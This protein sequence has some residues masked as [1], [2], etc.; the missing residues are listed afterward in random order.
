VPVYRIEDGFI[1][2]AGLGAKLVPP[3]SI[4]V[5]CRGA[6]F[7]PSTPSDLEVLLEAGGFDAALLAR[8]ERLAAAI[9]AR[10][11]T[12]YNLAGRPP[13][14]PAGRRLVLV[15]GQVTDDRSVTHGGAGIV[16]MAQL[17][18]RVRAAEPDAFI[19]FKPHPD[20]DARLRRGAL[21]DSEALRHVDRVIRGAALAPLLA[22]VDAVHVLSSQTGFEAL[23]RGRE[24]VCHGQPFYAGWGLTR[25]LAPIPRR[26][27][28]L[29]LAELVAGALIAYPRYC[30][31]VT[32]RPC[33][34]E[35]LVERLASLPRRRAPI[36]GT[37]ARV[38]A[39]WR[40]LRG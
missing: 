29:T 25:D 20:V 34:P 33:T 2:S 22:R 24:V 4:V 14:L 8:A 17:L 10:G 28:R 11:I 6:H 40:R 18:A 31:P 36:R 9:V 1:R 37:A 38:G 19:L 26:T 16:D 23:L 39:G 30:D 21:A 12:K 32:G 15:P 5:D 35:A 7:D 3:C 13:A 27:R